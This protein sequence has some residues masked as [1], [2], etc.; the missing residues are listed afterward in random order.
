MLEAASDIMDVS[1][2]ARWL[3]EKLEAMGY[4]VLV[5]LAFFG[6]RGATRSYDFSCQPE[7]IGKRTLSVAAYYTG[8]IGRSGREKGIW[9][10]LQN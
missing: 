8:G 3:A 6:G 9:Q 5:V 2:E 10:K 1:L 7:M 4:V